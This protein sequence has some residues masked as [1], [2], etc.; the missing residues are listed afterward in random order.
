MT[1][2]TIVNIADYEFTIKK[3]QDSVNYTLNTD[4]VAEMGNVLLSI[5]SNK[6]CKVKFIGL[7][8]N[9]VTHHLIQRSNISNEIIQE[10]VVFQTHFRSPAYLDKACS[11]LTIKDWNF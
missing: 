9:D 6:P 10:G 4:I 2:D 11:H 5:Q 1:A 7:D 3:E 8:G